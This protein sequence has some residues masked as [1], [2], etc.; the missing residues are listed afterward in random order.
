MSAARA[1]L[2]RDAKALSAAA[3][4]ELSTRMR[5]LAVRGDHPLAFADIASAP[6]WTCAADAE[7]ARLTRL[8]GAVLVSQRWSR[9]ISGAVLGRAAQAVGDDALE[10]LMNLPAVVAPEVLDAAAASGDAAALDQLG[11][12]ALIAASDAGVAIAARLSHLF[13]SGVAT[14]VKPTA[15][16][17]ALRTAEGLY[18][19]ADTGE[20]AP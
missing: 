2:W 11:A 3:G 20:A 5:R 17:L 12:S 13:P 19:Q 4:P 14:A 16:A 18:R 8:T 15:A 7:R 10:D 9:E 6:S 1:A